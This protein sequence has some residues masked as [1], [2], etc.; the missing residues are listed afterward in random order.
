MSKVTDKLLKFKW[1]LLVPTHNGTPPYGYTRTNE[2]WIPIP[3]TLDALEVAKD[4]LANGLSTRDCTD[5]LTEHTLSL[6]HI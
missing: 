2:M 1:P 4:L 3:E 6:I 5:W